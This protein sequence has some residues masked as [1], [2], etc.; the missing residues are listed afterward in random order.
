MYNTSKLNIYK[1]E[2]H[3]QILALIFFFTT[4]DFLHKTFEP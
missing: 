1:A 3:F 4:L 2:T